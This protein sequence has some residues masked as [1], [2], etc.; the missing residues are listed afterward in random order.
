MVITA[1]MR[2]FWPEKCPPD[3]EHWFF[4]STVKAGG[5]L[6]RQDAYLQQLNGSELG[7]KRRGTKAGFEFKGLVAILRDSE[8]G[9]LAPHGELWCKWYSNDLPLDQA[10]FMTIQKVRWIRKLD[11]LGQAIVEV[12]LGPDEAP[13]D[14]CSGRGGCN[15]TLTKVQ[16]V[17]LAGHWWTFC[18]EASG[19]VESAPNSLRSATQYV[20][21]MC[22]PKVNGDFLSY[23]GWLA[24]VANAKT[25]LPN[26]EVVPCSNQSIDSATTEVHEPWETR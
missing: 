2:W 6:P 21:S 13:L 11:T 23:P 18:F 8:L 14:G 5:G 26:R 20:R 1:E 4:Q 7:I 3:L 12:P 16:I 10:T 9:A 25:E 24:E 17:G 15:L 22:F 19:D